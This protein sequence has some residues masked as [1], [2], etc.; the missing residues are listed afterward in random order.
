M[1]AG[2]IEEEERPFQEE[3]REYARSL[4][5]EEALRISRTRMIAHVA[6]TFTV[7]RRDK[8]MQ[9]LVIPLKYFFLTFILKAMGSQAKR[10][11][12]YLFVF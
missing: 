9:D 1:L 3:K 12:I 4:R 10:E 5:W 6:G 8:I 11:Y 7:G 2:L